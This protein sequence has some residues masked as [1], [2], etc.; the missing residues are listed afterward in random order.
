MDIRKEALLAVANDCHTS[1]HKEMCAP[2]DYFGVFGSFD[3]C[4]YLLPNHNRFIDYFDGNTLT[5]I[6]N[7]LNSHEVTWRVVYKFGSLAIKLLND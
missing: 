4:V 7:Y 1:F 2:C 3:G 6:A 5:F